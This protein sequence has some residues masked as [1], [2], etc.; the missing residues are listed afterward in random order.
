LALALG[1]GFCY[2]CDFVRG[3]T[4][5]AEGKQQLAAA[6]VRKV[7]ET[8]VAVL[9]FGNNDVRKVVERKIGETHLPIGEEAF[10]N[11]F[12]DDLGD[13]GVA[14]VLRDFAKD[15]VN[16]IVR[17]FELLKEAATL[18]EQNAGDIKMLIVGAGLVEKS[19][20]LIETKLAR[21]RAHVYE[22]H[23]W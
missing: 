5:I 23:K 3:P 15:G 6:T 4:A 14:R 2:L 10:G 9:F 11:G 17:P 16:G 7:G 13:A 20:Q 8:G 22:M 21:S 19:I 12:V 1:Y 18:V